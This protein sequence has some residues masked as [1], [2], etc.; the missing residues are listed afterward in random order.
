MQIVD[1][2]HREFI[3][4]QHCGNDQANRIVYQTFH[5]LKNTVGKH[6]RKKNTSQIRV[7]GTRSIT[8]E[9]YMYGNRLYMTHPLLDFQECPFQNV[10]IGLSIKMKSLFIT[11]KQYLQKLDAGLLNIRPITSVINRVIDQS[12]YHH[13][14]IGSFSFYVV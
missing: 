7:N 12:L 11:S 6:K 8:K 3:L 1:H 2:V 9:V 4:Y 10:S 13:L 14:K 5:Q